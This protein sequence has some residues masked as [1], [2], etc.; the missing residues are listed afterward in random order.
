MFHVEQNGDVQISSELRDKFGIY[1][2]LL[3]KWQKAINLVSKNSLDDFWERHISDSLQ[4][5][6]YIFGRKVLDVG[7]GG[8]FPGMVLAMTGR[9]DVTCVDSDARKMTFLSEVAR[10][11]N[12]KVSLLTERIEKVHE[13]DFDTVCARGFSSLKNLIEI[14]RTKGRVGVFLKGAKLA[15][16]LAEAQNCY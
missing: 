4:I 2:A 10:Q 6:P 5:V 1:K 11:T 12:T 13:A 9:F 3:F 7:S 8:G 14:T 15:D 16:E